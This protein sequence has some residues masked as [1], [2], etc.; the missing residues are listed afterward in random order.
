MKI[1]WGGLMAIIGLLMNVCGTVT[2]DLGVYRLR[3]ARSRNLS[4]DSVHRFFQGLTTSDIFVAADRI[5]SGADTGNQAP[6]ITEFESSK[7][8]VLR[9]F[10]FGGVL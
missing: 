2:S 7:R 8:R 5:V 1:L 6:E 3:I 9:P 10:A 4:G